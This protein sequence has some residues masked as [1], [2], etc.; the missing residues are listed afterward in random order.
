MLFASLLAV[1]GMEEP[2]RETLDRN[3]RYLEKLAHDEPEHFARLQ[4][5]SKGFTS[6]SAERQKQLIKLDHELHQLPLSQQNRLDNAAVRYLEWLES[7]PEA[8]RQ[9]VKSAADKTARLQIIRE[10]KESQWLRSQPKALREHINSLKGP[11][12]TARIAKLRQEERERRQQWAIAAEFWEELVS[13]KPMPVR[14]S[15]F[16]LNVE[17]FVNEYLYPRLS[18]EEKDRLEKAQ[19]RWPEFPMTL[20]KIADRHPPALP[21]KTGPK[22]FRDLPKDVQA[23]LSA[24]LKKG[25]G[26]AIAPFAL[27]KAQ[28]E[29]PQFGQAIVGYAKNVPLPNE[30][31]AHNFQSLSPPMQ[32]FVQKVLQPRL[33]EDEKGRLNNAFNSW[34]EYP[35]TIQELAQAHNLQPPWLT[36]PG[37]WDLWKKYRVRGGIEQ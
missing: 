9:K 7:L 27:A 3:R 13:R 30:F 16:P 32:E 31:L 6:L 22:Y 4:R 29:W 14:L 12:R 33:N 20:V 1:A 2:S 28:G 5:Q 23:R 15:D 10:L 36:L 8:D 21:G 11:E 18:S 17:Q 25:K 35:V 24:K 26:E 37:G 19:G 34:P